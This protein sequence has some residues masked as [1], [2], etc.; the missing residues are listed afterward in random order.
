MQLK[1]L[2]EMRDLS[3]DKE[4][5]YYN[6][7]MWKVKGN[8]CFKYI[9]EVYDDVNECPSIYFFDEDMKFLYSGET[10]TMVLPLSK[11]LTEDEFYDKYG[12]LM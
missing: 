6:H 2:I 11:R 1:I 3:I 8:P 12:E 7:I 4:A 9:E 10:I 5:T